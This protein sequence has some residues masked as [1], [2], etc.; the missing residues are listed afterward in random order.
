MSLEHLPLELALQ[1]VSDGCLKPQDLAS[2]ARVSKCLNQVATACL[3]QDVRLKDYES[4]ALQLFYRSITETPALTKF[5]RTATIKVDERSDVHRVGEVVVKLHSIERLKLVLDGNVDFGFVLDKAALPKLGSLHIENDNVTFDD[6]VNFIQLPMIKSLTVGKSLG[7]ECSK[8]PP[9]APPPKI[10]HR[11][12]LESFKIHITNDFSSELDI[13]LACCPKLK[14]F[15]CK[16]SGGSFYDPYISSSRFPQVLSRCRDTLHI[17]Q[18]DSD[19]ITENIDDETFAD[20]SCLRNLKTLEASIEILFEWEGRDKPA[21]RKG[22]HTRLPSSLETLKIN[23]PKGFA[24]RSSFR[25][26]DDGTPER[27]FADENLAWVV[28]IAENKRAHL[29]NLSFVRIHEA[30]QRTC[31][32]ISTAPVLC[33]PPPA[34]EA[35]FR[36]AGVGIELYLRPHIPSYREFYSRYKNIS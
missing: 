10:E 8:I 23:I 4:E 15:V 9:S 36:D 6:L 12:S 21:A 25:S 29:P 17:L 13:L 28:E 32:P 16:I 3:Y 18:L 5:T 24:F 33:D 27:G 11:S 7:E 31:L 1:I 34:I 22:L 35:A 14:S 30:W 19:R 2:L 20:L 26:N